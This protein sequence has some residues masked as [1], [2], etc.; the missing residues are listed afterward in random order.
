MPPLPLGRTL[1]ELGGLLLQ[2]CEDLLLGRLPDLEAS[3]LALRGRVPDLLA[4]FAVFPLVGPL[5]LLTQV[6]LAEHGVYRIQ[7]L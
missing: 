6:L 3:L 7:Y 1:N 2:L 5:A 4:R